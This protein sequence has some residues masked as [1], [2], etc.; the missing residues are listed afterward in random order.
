MLRHLPSVY[1]KTVLAEKQKNFMKAFMAVLKCELRQ[2]MLMNVWTDKSF[3][4][5]NRAGWVPLLPPF[6][7]T[8]FLTSKDRIKVRSI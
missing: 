8:S 6:S 7:L 5:Q 1:H 2:T 3:Q 4:E